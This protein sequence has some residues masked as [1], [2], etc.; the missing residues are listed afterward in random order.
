[1]TLRHLLA[2]QTQEPELKYKHRYRI[3][4]ENGLWR[5]YAEDNGKVAKHEFV[6]GNSLGEVLR[7]L[8]QRRIAHIAFA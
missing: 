6:W 1:M 4:Y 3:K 2:T 5:C 7:R 8:R